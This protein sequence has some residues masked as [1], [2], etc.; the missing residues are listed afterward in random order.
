MEENVAVIA[1]F[2]QLVHLPALFFHILI[3]L[4]LRVLSNIIV[5][6][7]SYSFVFKVL[8]LLMES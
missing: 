3:L 2:L 5:N 1:T 8:K 4:H 7:S 6:F